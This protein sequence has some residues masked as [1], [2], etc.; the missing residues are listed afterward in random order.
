MLEHPRT[1]S[2]LQR[3]MNIAERAEEYRKHMVVCSAFEGKNI[4]TI[5]AGKLKTDEPKNN[6]VVMKTNKGEGP[7]ARSSGMMLMYSRG[8]NIAKKGIQQN[9]RTETRPHLPHIHNL[10]NTRAI[11]VLNKTMAINPAENETSGDIICWI[12][13]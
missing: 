10:K 8:R 2:I 7:P 1:R 3:K 6:I 11:T 12:R 9:T 4:C 13:F 5:P